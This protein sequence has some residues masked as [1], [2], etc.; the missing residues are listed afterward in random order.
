VFLVR[1]KL[2]NLSRAWVASN[3][4]GTYK[5]SVTLG[6][7]IGFGNLNGAITANVVSLDRLGDDEK[8]LK[9]CV[10]KYRATDKPRYRLGHTIVLVYI[11]IGFMCSA[12]F[13]V[14]L[15]R[16]NIRRSRGE[17]DEVITGVDNKL[18]DEKNGRYE[19]VLAARIDRGDQWSGFRYVI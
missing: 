16:E 18:A 7:A 19:T 5:R 14:L 15:Q 9:L 12:L 10:I 11:A 17:R 8:H 2:L 13:G 1:L 3:V 6:M 4:E